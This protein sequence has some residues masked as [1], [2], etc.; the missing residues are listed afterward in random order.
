[1]MMKVMMMPVHL[2]LE[3]AL[4]PELQ[5]VDGQLPDVLRLLVGGRVPGQP[6]YRLLQ[7]NREIKIN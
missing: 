6:G 2:A 4:V 1:M 5:P 7:A 3:G